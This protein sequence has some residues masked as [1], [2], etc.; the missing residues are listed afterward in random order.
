MLID[1]LF[2]G[3]WLKDWVFGFGSQGFIFLGLGILVLSLL[4]YFSFY[5]EKTVLFHVLL[6][7]WGFLVLWFLFGLWGYI[8]AILFLIEFSFRYPNILDLAG[9]GNLLGFSVVFI[10][11]LL[12]IFNIIF[13]GSD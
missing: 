10:V 13:G 2:L 12:W 4:S 1:W 7:F 6:V 8:A 5:Y 9:E 3:S 11:P